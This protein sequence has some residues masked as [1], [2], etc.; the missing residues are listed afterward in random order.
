MN[1][2]AVTERES[3]IL[4]VLLAKGTIEIHFGSRWTLQSKWKYVDSVKG[5]EFIHFIYRTV[6]GNRIPDS[7]PTAINI[8]KN[9]TFYYI[10]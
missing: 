7:A 8:I 6:R 9:W 10:C 5:A 3:R 4:I 1:D 2:L